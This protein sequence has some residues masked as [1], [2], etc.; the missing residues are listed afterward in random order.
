MLPGVDFTQKI[1]KTVL[2]HHEVI[3]NVKQPHS[4][5]TVIF[6]SFYAAVVMM[7]GPFHI[8]ALPATL[9]CTQTILFPHLIQQFRDLTLQTT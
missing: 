8:M 4:D 2:P 9:Q 1:G 7:I 6:H 5:Y 3:K